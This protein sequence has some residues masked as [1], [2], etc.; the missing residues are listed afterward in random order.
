MSITT[1]AAVIPDRNPS[2]TRRGVNRAGM[3]VAIVVGYLGLTG[4]SAFAQT[5]DPSGAM[6]TSLQ[7]SLTGTLIPAA[8]ALIV[9][10][11][12]FALAVKYVKKAQSKA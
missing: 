5:A 2:R 10:G 12:V 8:S 9:V 6:F 1:S 4:T 11:I 3:L 7:T